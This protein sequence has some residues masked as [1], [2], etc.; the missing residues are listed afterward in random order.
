M[1]NIPT[2]L[3]LHLGESNFIKLETQYEWM[4]VICTSEVG[5]PGQCH[6]PKDEYLGPKCNFVGAVDQ[7]WGCKSLVRSENIFLSAELLNTSKLC[8]I[9]NG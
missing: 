9:L 3:M 4:T 1:L 8:I 7:K 6:T 2:L 5:Q